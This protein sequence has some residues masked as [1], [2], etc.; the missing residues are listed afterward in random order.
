[1]ENSKRARSTGDA[2]R[3]VKQRSKQKYKKKRRYHGKANGKTKTNQ[4][5]ILSENLMR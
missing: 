5:N 2:G 1:M 3:C 4:E